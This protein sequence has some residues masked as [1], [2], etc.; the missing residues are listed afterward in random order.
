[1][2]YR[3]K[4]WL[5]AAVSFGSALIAGVII[6]K[7]VPASGGVENPAL[8][9]PVLLVVVGLVMAASVAWWR[10]TD[11]VQKQGQLVSWWWGGNTGALAMLV[12]LV[13]LTGRH[14]DISLGAIYLFLAQFAGMAVVFLAWKFHGRGVAE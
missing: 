5:L 2:T 1:M 10:K 9:L 6:G 13:V 12:T 8:V 11:D 7:T 4:F 3:T 14:S